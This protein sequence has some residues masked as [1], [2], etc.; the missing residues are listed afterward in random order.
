MQSVGS[1]LINRNRDFILRQSEPQELIEM[2]PTPTNKFSS[3]MPLNM[4]ENNKTPGN[5]SKYRYQQEVT[6]P[7]Q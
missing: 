3:R 7:V 1:N 5:S 2:V 6:S 4:N